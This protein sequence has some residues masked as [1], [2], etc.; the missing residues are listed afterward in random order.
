VLEVSA[1]ANPGEVIDAIMRSGT[2]RDVPLSQRLMPYLMKVG[3]SQ[4]LT[5]C[6]SHLTH[7]K[8]RL[9]VHACLSTDTCILA[10]H[11]AACKSGSCTRFIS[12]LRA[13]LPQFAF[14]ILFAL[15]VY[16]REEVYTFSRGQCPEGPD[17]S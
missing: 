10:A 7:K 2:A 15:V 3:V 13:A 12:T 14:I 4:C 9:P 6:M 1:G 8:R 11:K 5:S 16:F 17:G